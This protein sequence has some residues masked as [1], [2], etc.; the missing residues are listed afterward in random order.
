MLDSIISFFI[1]WSLLKLYTVWIVFGFV[2]TCKVSESSLYEDEL[3][4]LY[5]ILGEK[6]GREVHHLSRP[7]NWA[8]NIFEI[9]G[10]LSGPLVLSWKVRDALAYVTVF[11]IPKRLAG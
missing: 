5:R 9:L 1:T 2:I 10:V 11:L 6:L 7:A 8:T 3:S 4:F